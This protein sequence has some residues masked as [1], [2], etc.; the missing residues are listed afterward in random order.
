MNSFDWN[1]IR[2]LL[3]TLEQGSLLGA[4]RVLRLSQ[5]T[6]SRQVAELE[7]QLGALLFERTGRGLA[8][9][10]TA[11]LLA[12]AARTM[13][14]GALQLARVLQGELARET[15]TVRLTA[16]TPV[17]IYL[18]PTLLARMRV[19]LPDIRIEL[20]A[21]NAVSNLLRRE[22]DIAVRMV[23]PQQNTLIARKLGELRIGAYAHRSYLARRGTPRQIADLLRHDLIAG[24]TDT[25]V[26]QGFN[27][28]GYPVGPEAFV[29][30]CDDMIV[31]WRAVAA[32]VGIGFAP[33]Y[34][35]RSTPEVVQ[36]LGGV[37]KVPPLP[38]WL[39]VH[40]EIRSSPRIR[41]VYDFLAAELPLLI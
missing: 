26:L 32:G 18:M 33:G 23:R 30:R 15:G 35:A 20:V 6:V 31:Q 2:T 16:S 34:V 8:P 11:L 14:S 39:V 27:R 25:T 5:P 13:E 12:D 36:V 10:A 29:L 19:S 22:A 28:L 17:A 3:V 37:L 21:S 24:D 7:R 4:A 38:M 40:R 1:L 9:T 41:A